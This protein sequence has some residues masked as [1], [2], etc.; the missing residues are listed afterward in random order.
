MDPDYKYAKNVRFSCAYLFRIKINDKYFLVKDEQGRNTFQPVG[1]VYKYTDDSFFSKTHAVQCTRFGNTSDLDSDLRIIVPRKYAKKFEHWYKKE[2]GRESPQDLSREFKEE[3]I[4][5]ISV[6]NTDVFETITYKFCGTHLEGGRLGQN[7]YQ[8]RFA[9]VVEL[10]PTPDQTKEFLKL[11]EYES[12]EYLFATKDEIYQEGCTITNQV[13]T[14]SHH[15]KK[16]LTE[17]EERLKRTRHSGKY[18]TCK[19]KTQVENTPIIGWDELDST[20]TTRPFTFISYNS[21]LGN[22]VWEFCCKNNPPLENLWIDR[23]QVSENWKEN[24]EKAINSQQCSKAVLFINKQYLIRSTPC[25]YEASLIVNNHIPHI[26]ILLDIDDKEIIKAI[27]DWINCD[28][29]DKDKLRTFKKLFHYDDD[30]AHINCSLFTLKNEDTKRILQAY[31]N[32]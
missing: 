5:R 25:Y 22:K 7:D 16:I 31:T 9:D 2:K 32:L 20:D 15:T 24:V 28:V 21:V 23:K 1:G 3:V 30:T 8:L 18:F 10:I 27:Q 6:I 17:D 12:N 26:I 14:I 19:I 4:D 29:A 13:P 11:L